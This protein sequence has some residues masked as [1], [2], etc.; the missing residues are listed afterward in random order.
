MIEYREVIAVVSGGSEDYRV[1][2]GD[3]YTAVCMHSCAKPLQLLPL[4]EAGLEQTYLLTPDELAFMVSSHLGQDE[5]MAV[6]HSILRKTGLRE[7]D[8]ILPAAAPQGR[9]AH[10]HWLDRQEP[11]RKRYHPCSGN[12]LA[13]MLTHREKT[14]SP[15]GYERRDSFIQK[16][17][18][19]LLLQ[20]ADAAP[21]ELNVTTDGCG[22]PA[23]TLPAHRIANVYRQLAGMAGTDERIHALVTAVWQ[24]PRM[25]EGDGCIATVLNSQPGIFAKTGSGGL[26]VGALLD[27]D[28]GFM[29]R[30]SR[31]W[32]AA[33]EVLISCLSELHLLT[34]KI[35]C[36]LKDCFI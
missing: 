1:F 24:H 5:H 10:A 22:V 7:E 23:F 16:Q 28:L 35:V 26:L 34:P 3:A 17:I 32:K 4:L 2:C 36:E 19:E 12:H 18:G 27:E 15:I 31:G 25:I 14:G 29:I 20:F 30:S 13:M 21:P 11:L 6:F 9:I 33:A 8:M